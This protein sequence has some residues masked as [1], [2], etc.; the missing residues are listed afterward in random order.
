MR[1]YLLIIASLLSIGWSN[2]GRSEDGCIIKNVKDESCASGRRLYSSLDARLNVCGEASDTNDNL[3][4]S[5]LFCR[6]PYKCFKDSRSA[7]ADGDNTVAWYNCFLGAAAIPTDE[8]EPVSVSHPPLMGCVVK[9]SRDDQCPSGR[10]L[11]SGIDQRLSACSDA[12]N[13]S[14]EII[15][16][17]CRSNFQCFKDFKSAYVAGQTEYSWYNCYPGAETISQSDN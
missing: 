5:G 14:S 8:V 16:S 1:K 10:R 3:E 4:I 7:Y 13:D 2:I 11:T 17:Y 9:N 15:G 12:G 6:S